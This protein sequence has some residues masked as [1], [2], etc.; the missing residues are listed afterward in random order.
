MLFAFIL[1]AC[2]GGSDSPSVNSVGTGNKDLFSSWAEQ[3]PR[4]GTIV[5]FTGMSFSG[6]HR[7]REFFPNS[8]GAC[9]CVIA[10]SGTES[11]GTIVVADC[12]FNF[13]TGSFDPGCTTFDG[14]ATYSKTS[15]TLTICTTTSGSC[16]VL[17]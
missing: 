9:D 1:G 7:W 13:N 3:S 10:F 17:K 11:S 14:S 2:G 6:P 16:A 15:D 8:L 5:D 12:Q 4:Q